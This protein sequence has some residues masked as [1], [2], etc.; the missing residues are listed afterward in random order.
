MKKQNFEK[1]I[2]DLISRWESDHR[3]LSHSIDYANFNVDDDR[4][5]GMSEFEFHEYG[6]GC[7]QS[8]TEFFNDVIIRRLTSGM[9]PSRANVEK[10]KRFLT[11]Q[12]VKKDF[13]PEGIVPEYQIVLSGSGWSNR[14][15]IFVDDLPQVDFR[16]SVDYLNC[17]Y[18]LVKRMAGR[19]WTENRIK[20]VVDH[21]RK[22]VCGDQKYSLFMACKSN[23]LINRTRFLYLLVEEK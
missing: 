6:G 10:L 17:K 11:M 7:V 1:K 5:E 14:T 13:I 3:L 19:R 2:R 23:P 15:Q 12:A 22:D 21:I 18:I 20:Q 9:E 16:G 4:D 8:F